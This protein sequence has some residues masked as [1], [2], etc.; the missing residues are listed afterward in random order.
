[1]GAA[2]STP[3]TQEVIKTTTKEQ[4]DPRS[5]SV[6]NR[7]PIRGLLDPRSPQEGRTPIKSLRA[8]SANTH[9][10]LQ[11]SKVRSQTLDP[12]SPREDRTPLRKTLEDPRSPTECRTPVPT[13]SKVDEPITP[14]KEPIAM[15]SYPVDIAES[16]STEETSTAHDASFETDEFDCFMKHLESVSIAKSTPLKS[17]ASPATA[18]RS[19][20]PLQSSSLENVLPTHTTPIKSPLA[21]RKKM[22]ASADL[23][24]ENEPKSAECTPKASKAKPMTFS[25]TTGRAI[26]IR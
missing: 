2:S 22:S 16:T 26:H 3:Q 11:S 15:E 24:K 9:T 5:P 18:R 19:L 8:A 14:Y 23:G 6:L 4:M 20:A 10:P 12:R 17:T 21:E 13:A 7:T 25:P 1:M